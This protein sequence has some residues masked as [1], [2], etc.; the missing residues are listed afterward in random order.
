MKFGKLKIDK[1]KLLSVVAALLGAA[2]TLL[3]GKVEAD[4]RKAMKIELKEEI[5]KDLLNNK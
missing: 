5:M 1:I 3:S 4:K 2:G